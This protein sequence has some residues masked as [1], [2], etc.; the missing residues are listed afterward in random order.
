MEWRADVESRWVLDRDGKSTGSEASD[1][2]GARSEV[3]GGK[4]MLE[5]G[6]KEGATLGRK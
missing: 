2:D 4:R 6:E 5:L 3:D 1:G